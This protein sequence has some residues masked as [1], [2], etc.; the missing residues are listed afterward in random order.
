VVKDRETKT[1][2][3]EKTLDIKQKKKNRLSVKQVKESGFSID[4]SKKK[5]ERKMRGKRIDIVNSFC[6]GDDVHA[7]ETN[8]PPNFVSMHLVFDPFFTLG[9]YIHDNEICA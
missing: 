3:M 6:I 4:Y 2:K 1:E 5:K 9:G 8:F 7:R